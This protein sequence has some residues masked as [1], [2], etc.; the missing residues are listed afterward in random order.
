M[1]VV[2][3]SKSSFNI[4][5]YANAKKVEVSGSNY[6]V[7]YGTSTTATYAQADYIVRIVG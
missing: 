3:I 1:V 4:I 5:E 7:T 2:V 6:V